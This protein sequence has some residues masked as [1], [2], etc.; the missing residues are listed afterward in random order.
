MTTIRCRAKNPGKCAFHN[1]NQSEFLQPQAGKVLQVLQKYREEGMDPDK[2]FIRTTLTSHYMAHSAQV[3]MYLTQN[4]LR[5]TEHPNYRHG[6]IE[7]TVDARGN[8]QIAAVAGAERFLDRQRV[9]RKWL[10]LDQEYRSVKGKN[11][12]RKLFNQPLLPEQP[13]P[14]FKD[15]A[16]L[17]EQHYIDAGIT[18]SP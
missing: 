4:R 1:G 11:R 16:A 14:P 12:L 5:Y 17:Y 7:F 18:T 2:G 8:E 9:Y 10:V 6:T 15:W 13:V 3:Q